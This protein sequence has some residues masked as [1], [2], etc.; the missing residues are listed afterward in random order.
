[1]IPYQ[2][3]DIAAEIAAP[4]PPPARPAPWAEETEEYLGQLKNYK[5][6]QRQKENA[7][8]KHFD[9]KWQA[10]WQ[11][12]QKSHERD[13]T[14]AQAASLAKKERLDIHAGLAKAESALATQVR[15]EK[16]G[17]AKFL[18]RQHVPT[19]TSPGCDCGWHSQTAKH[20]IRHCSLRPGRQIMLEK[21]GTSDYRLLVTTPKGLKAVTAWL[22]KLN[23]LPQFSLATEQLYQG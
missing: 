21:A 1:M 5:A 16:I 22:M 10:R 3:K 9:G 4:T 17:F 12:Y 13:P 20:I 7:I 11:T 18:H 6:L 14:A 23:L 15:T 19:V 2:K 8:R